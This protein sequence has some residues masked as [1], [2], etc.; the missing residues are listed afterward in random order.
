MSKTSKSDKMYKAL[1]KEGKSKESA[2]RIVQ[3][4]TNQSLNKCSKPK[5]NKSYGPK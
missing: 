2:A 4:K 5:N 3:A 1:I